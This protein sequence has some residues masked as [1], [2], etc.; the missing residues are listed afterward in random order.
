[1]ENT[2]LRTLIDAEAIALLGT[3]DACKSTVNNG[4]VRY[5]WSDELWVEI[6]F[7]LDVHGEW[8]IQQGF[9][10]LLAKKLN[11]ARS[12]RLKK[13][14]SIATDEVLQHVFLPQ[15]VTGAAMAI[16]SGDCFL[17]SERQ[18]CR[19]FNGRWQF[20]GGEVE[21]EETPPR[22]AVRETIQETDVAPE[23]HR[24][25]YLGI[26]VVT[27]PKVYIAY[28]FLWK[29]AKTPNNYCFK[30]TEPEKMGPWIWKSRYE[31]LQLPI[32]PGMKEILT[33]V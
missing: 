12:Q 32:M 25:T 16:Q 8:F 20:P 29:I 21:K 19:D 24:I 30:N 1:M 17:V 27:A 28:F 18:H 14:T 5:S 6:F 31:L 26:S 4:R 33:G 22:A 23:L 11:T 3:P 7:T 9:S 13:E 15:G 2:R 10:E